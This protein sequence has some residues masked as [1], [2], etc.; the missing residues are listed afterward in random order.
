MRLLPHAWIITVTL[1]LVNC[2][3][4]EKKDQNMIDQND[5]N[6]LREEVADHKITVY[7]VFTRLFG[8]SK[9][10]NATYGTIEEN[11]V[12]KFNDINPEALE[13]IRKMGITH[14][15]YTG[16]IEHA[17]MTDFSQYG[18]PADD[19]DVVKGRAG[20]PYAIKDYYDVAPALAVD[21]P[22]R[23]REFEALVKRTHDKGLKVLIDFVPN[24]VARQY[25]SDARPAGVK[26]LG[27]NDDKT[28]SFTP[29]NNFYYLPG[30]SFVVP[31]EYQPLG[32]LPHPTKDGQFS[33]SPA[34]VTGNDQFT[35]SPGINEWFE[36]VKLNYGVD[37]R[38]GRAPHF[39]PVPDTWNKMRDILLYW[40][41][42]GVDGFRCD[43]A[44][45]VPVEFW[46]WV[47]PQVQQ[48]RKDILFI[49]EIYNPAAYRSYIE[50]GRFDYLYDKVGLYDT[51]RA[52]MEGRAE[53]NYI[54]QNWKQTQGLNNR[55][56]RFLENHDE[57]RIASRFFAG[58]ARKGIPGM[59]VTATLNSGPVMV[60]FGQEVGE[61]A[62]GTEGFS[63]DDGRTTIFDYWG[64]ENHQLWMN[65]GLF[66]G[67]GLTPE[68]K[69]LR[70]FY[71]RL[72]NLCRDNEAIRRGGLYDLQ[73]FNVQNRTAG[74]DG[75][76][77]Y[78]FL[79]FTEKDRVMVLVNFDPQHAKEVNIRIPAN[80]FAAMGLPRDQR[81]ELKELLYGKTEIAFDAAQITD[82]GNMVSGIPVSLPPL[83]AFVFRIGQ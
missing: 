24:H 13:E 22:N 6:L 35:N 31:R 26:D 47:I 69:K 52:V 63:G 1:L 33:E 75:R 23:M 37:I 62:P 3:P 80:A 16:V 65:F 53:A 70:D 36:T 10:K 78:S 38:N 72:L 83:S 9:S 66:N 39:N 29:G 42:K 14:V 45:M 71:S 43:M 54:S 76:F 51:V 79:R 18:I 20:S 19:A 17:T 27:E 30:T 12:G 4:G 73:Q 67:V 5:E 46:G 60:Y 55:L 61:P 34:R 32:N 56:L 77:I 64:V 48:A 68:M 57:Q 25:R 50:D 58:D 59:T 49:A 28:R 82:K 81:Y 2:N 11:G 41:G 74:Y 21:V 8:N 44:E 40:A 15:W 7:Q